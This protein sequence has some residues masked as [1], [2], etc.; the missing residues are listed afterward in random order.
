MGLFDEIAEEQIA[1]TPNRCPYERLR[2][3]LSDEDFADFAK[4]LDDR[5]IANAAIVRA[6][7]RRDIKADPKGIAA[8]RKGLCACAR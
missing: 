1:T 2:G 6:L 4:A 7:K 5:S 3:E 8:H